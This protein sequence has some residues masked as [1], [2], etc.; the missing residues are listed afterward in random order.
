MEWNLAWVSEEGQIQK[1]DLVVDRS[2]VGSDTTFGLTSLFVRCLVLQQRKGSSYGE[3]WRDQ[4]W[5]G[6]VGRV[7]SKAARLKNMVWRDDPVDSATEPISETLMDM[8]NLAAFAYMNYSD[9]NKWGK[10]G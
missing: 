9:K 2:C 8:I 4:G 5:L 7:L 3:A 10:R 6:N 1:T